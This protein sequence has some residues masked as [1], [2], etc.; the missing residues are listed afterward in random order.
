MIE[1]ITK[2]SAVA[3]SQRIYKNLLKN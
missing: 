2:V 1:F 3:M